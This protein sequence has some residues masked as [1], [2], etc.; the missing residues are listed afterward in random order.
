MEQSLTGLS[1]TTV[2]RAIARGELTSRRLVTACLE[3][4]EAREQIVGAWQF[5][6]PA[7]ALEQAD[8]RLMGR[9]REWRW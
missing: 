2:A 6:D 7:L 5:L 8:R 4:I 3:R 1:A 9:S